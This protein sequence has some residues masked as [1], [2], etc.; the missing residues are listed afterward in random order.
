MSDV[1]VAN[2]KETGCRQLWKST[3]D[4]KPASHF[5]FFGEII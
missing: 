4:V 5:K 1:L 2:I 3:F